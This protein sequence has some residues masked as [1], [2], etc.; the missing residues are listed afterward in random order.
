[1]SI[2]YRYVSH[3][4]PPILKNIPYLLVQYVFLCNNIHIN[5]ID[6]IY[7]KNNRESRMIINNGLSHC[8]V[9]TFGVRD[10]SSP[11]VLSIPH[12]GDI[13]PDD[14][15]PRSDMPYEIYDRPADRFV[16]ELFSDF[17]PLNLATIKAEF[18]RVYV[19]V[20]R[21]QYD[22]A[23]EIMENPDDW[24]YKISRTTGTTMIWGDIYD[25]P[26]Y[27]RKLS[28]TEMRYR[29]ATCYLP[30]HEILTGIIH[31]TREKYK[32][33]VLLD[34]HSM[35]QYNPHT[36]IERP[37]IDIGTRHGLSCNTHLAE[38]LK[39]AFENLGYYV[40][41]NE[42]FAGGEITQRYGWPEIQQNA[43]QIE[44]RRDLYMNEDTRQK[45]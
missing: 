2:C 24:G 7:K 32:W 43:L 17:I 35:A 11:L 33:V 40:G 42:K 23:T 16:D 21:R 37:E 13:Y 19:D 18:P 20:N 45:K 36:H 41:I 28:K 3:A 34:L 8:A 27:D 38:F 1:M 15:N 14:F 25:T 9:S 30:Y 26:L 31:Q 10:L 39:Q 6:A 4:I 44:F 29:L 12:S 5:C 22:L